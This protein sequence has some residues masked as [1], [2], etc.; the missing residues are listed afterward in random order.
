MKHIVLLVP[1]YVFQKVY[2]S[3]FLYYYIGLSVVGYYGG[4]TAGDG[5]CYCSSCVTSDNSVVA[6]IEMDRYIKGPYAYAQYAVLYYNDNCQCCIRVF[7]YRFR[8]STDYM[9]VSIF[10]VLLSNRFIMDL[11]SRL[12]SYY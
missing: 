11:I 3:F 12:I 1:D 8:V 7:N 4:L 6:E 10:F 5:S 2:L 9:T